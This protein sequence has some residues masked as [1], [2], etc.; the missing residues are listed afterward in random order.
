MIRG[1]VML[2]KVMIVAGLMSIS[3]PAMALSYYLER[4]WHKNGNQFC[5]YSNGT[6]LNV[7]W[8]NCPLKIDG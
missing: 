6:I 2:K 7:G 4:S 1:I 8:R 5:Q 3:Q